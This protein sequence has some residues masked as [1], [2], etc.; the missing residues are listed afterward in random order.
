MG[1]SLKG[2]LADCNNYNITT[3]STATYTVLSA[4]MILHVTRTT[5]GACTI[6]IP[7]ALIAAGSVYLLVKDAGI[8]AFTNNIDIETEGAELVD[9]EVKA[10]IDTDGGAIELYTKNGDLFIKSILV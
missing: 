7:S 4:S 1:T 9:G 5:A 10:I 6:T 8:N 3:V 2:A